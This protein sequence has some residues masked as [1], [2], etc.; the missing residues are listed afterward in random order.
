MAN[1]SLSACLQL[2]K[3]IPKPPPHRITYDRICKAKERATEYVNN[4]N[5]SGTKNILLAVWSIYLRTVH[6]FSQDLSWNNPRNCKSATVASSPQVNGVSEGAKKK[7]RSKKKKLTDSINKMINEA[8]DDEKGALEALM[9]ELGEDL[10]CQ[11]TFE[12]K[13]EKLIAI[14]TQLSSTY[15][16]YINKTYTL[17]PAK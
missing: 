15:S 5:I 1:V 17:L 13:K 10:W 9:A 6:F 4:K 12:E 3:N 16:A 11:Y 14:D 2:L 7:L 8:Q